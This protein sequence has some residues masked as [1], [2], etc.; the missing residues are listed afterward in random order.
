MKSLIQICPT[1][2][3]QSSQF[4]ITSTMQPTKTRVLFKTPGLRRAPASA[5]VVPNTFS[6]QS[7]PHASLAPPVGLPVQLR[8]SHADDLLVGGDV[9]QVG[10]PQRQ[11]QLR[12]GRDVLVLAGRVQETCRAREADTVRWVMWGWCHVVA[13]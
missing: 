1:H 5:H 10:Q 13:C 12:L 11:L 6:T 8:Q 3:D 7:V 4:T 2:N 9:Q